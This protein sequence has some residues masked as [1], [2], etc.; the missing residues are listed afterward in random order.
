MQDVVLR[1]RGLTKRFGDLVAVDNLDLEVRR[2]EV[3]GFLGP[4]GSGKSTT[5]GMVLGLIKPTSG[6]VDRLGIP[7]RRIGAIIESPAFYPFLSGRDNLRALAVAVDG[8]GE[9]EIET[10]LD[11]VGLAGA[12]HRKYQT[13]SL[14]MKQR[15]GIASTLLCDPE[16]V[17]LD[18]PTNGLDPAGQQEIRALIP[19]LAEEG[20]SVLLASH[21][22]HEV[23][24]VCDRVAI[25]RRGKLLAQGL[26]SDLTQQQAYLEIGVD[27]L[28]AASEVIGRLECVRDV[29][30][31][32]GFLHVDAEASAAS[33][34]SKALAEAG[35]YVSSLSQERSSLED[36]FL[37]LTSEDGEAR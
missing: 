9:G 20:R 37:D 29:H 24:Q 17:I 33:L 19:R 3:L 21:L 13:Y 14:G 23:E 2:G 15:L 34:I 12:G 25:L 26:V 10:L 7:L 4:N 32:D 16:L 30:I 11:L 1:T 35:L 36:V 27:N 8:A 31:E 6:A 5:V 18:E 28:Q 22:L